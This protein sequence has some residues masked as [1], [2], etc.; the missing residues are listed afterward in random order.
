MSCPIEHRLREHKGMRESERRNLWTNSKWKNFFRKGEGRF[1]NEF[2]GGPKRTNPKMPKA[3]TTLSEEKLK[4]TSRLEPYWGTRDISKNQAS[5]KR[6]KR[7]IEYRK[8][9]WS[10]RKRK[11]D[12]SPAVN[13]IKERTGSRIGDGG[14][15]MQN[16]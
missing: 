3:L 16:R 7:G 8:S 11:S 4:R 9:R 2:R 5:R 14:T 15:D 12:C 13:S 10:Q 1:I 6:V